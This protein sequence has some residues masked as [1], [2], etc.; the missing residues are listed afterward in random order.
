MGMQINTNQFFGMTPL[1]GGKGHPTLKI[2]TKLAQPAEDYSMTRDAAKAPV[3]NGQTAGE[4]REKDA[5]FNDLEKLSMPVDP[6]EF[7]YAKTS[8]QKK[9]SQID[10]PTLHKKVPLLCNPPTEQNEMGEYALFLM[11]AHGGEEDVKHCLAKGINPKAIDHRP[12][13]EATSLMK[14]VKA[15]NE[16]TAKVLA[17]HMDSQALT[18]QNEKGQTAL[19]LAVAKHNVHL[20]KMLSTF[21]QFSPSGGLQSTDKKRPMLH[22]QD[23]SGH[24]QDA[25]HR[26]IL[27]V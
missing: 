19:D 13:E 22:H 11:A 20:I 26:V 10:S 25:K 8:V 18:Y 12:G 15:G 14:A 4:L 6:D 1:T 16:N 24:Q 21:Y 5:F 23:H 3:V 17:R 7:E 2:K 27:S 9:I